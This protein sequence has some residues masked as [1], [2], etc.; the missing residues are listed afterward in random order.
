MEGRGKDKSNKEVIAEA[1]AALTAASL[2]DLVFRLFNK[3]SASETH[4]CLPLT[5]F[6]RLSSLPKH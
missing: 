3:F 5:F 2:N 1:T 6:L 4:V